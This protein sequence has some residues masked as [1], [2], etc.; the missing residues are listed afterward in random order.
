VENVVS[1]GGII[2]QFDLTGRRCDARR[3]LPCA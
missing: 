3:A 1:Y 2:E